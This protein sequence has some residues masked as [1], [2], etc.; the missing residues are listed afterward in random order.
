MNL[1]SI[2]GSRASGTSIVDGMVFWG[3]GYEHL[4]SATVHQSVL[5]RNSGLN[6]RK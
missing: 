1:I 2:R 5:P 3:S 6:G 4:N